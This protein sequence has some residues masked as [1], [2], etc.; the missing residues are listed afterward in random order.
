MKVINLI[1]I[2]LKSLIQAHQNLTSEDF[3][4][5][6]SHYGIDL[7]NDEINDLNGLIT[8][9]ESSKKNISLFDGF[10]LGYKIPQIGKE[11]D[12]LKF[13]HDKIINI[14]IKNNS[15]EEKILK[16]LQKNNYYLSSSGKNVLNF[17]YISQTGFLYQLTSENKIK[18]IEADY[19]IQNLSS[20]YLDTDNID[21]FFDPSDYLVSPFNSTNRFL[22]NQYFLTLQQD[23]IKSQV[24]SI[25]Q[26]PSQFISII[27]SAGTGKTLLVYDICKTFL[28][29]NKK[30]LIIHCGALNEGHLILNKHGWNIISIRDYQSQNISNY[31]LIIIDEAQRIYTN[32]L[33]DIV[34]KISN[35]KLSCI[36]S[37]DKIQTLHSIEAYRDID[38]K[39]NSINNIKTY[40][41]SEKIRTN[42]EIANFIKMLFNKNKKNAL[43]NNG[44]IRI[45]YFTNIDDAKDFISSLKSKDWEVLRFTPSQYNSEAHEKYTDIN[46]KTS[47]K[48][49]GQEFDSVAIVLDSNF[50]YNSDGYLFYAANSYYDPTKMLF[51]N[52]TR[53][54]KRLNIIIIDNKIILNRCISILNNNN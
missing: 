29:S 17:A 50:K 47:H 51:Q 41:L 25:I 53:A 37:Y 13:S 26:S 1:N 27:G 38:K 35:S 4:K 22:N 40:K 24:F 48:I 8:K 10:Y 6:I 46:E 15:T 9:I 20:D 31:D 28:L 32:Q 54:R 14:E 44:N 39:I 42:K 16:Q 33:D 30:T 11:F 18:I 49:I 5:F 36:F 2:N 3:S 34:G 45:N 23:A 21:V 19:L 52:L 43:T 7:K 12:L